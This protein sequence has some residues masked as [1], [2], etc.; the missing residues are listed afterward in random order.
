MN[1]YDEFL[2]SFFNYEIYFLSNSSLQMQTWGRAQGESHFGG[3]L[4]CTF[5]SWATIVEYKSRFKLST[6]QFENIQ[7]LIDMLESF[8]KT[9]DYPTKPSEY[10]ALLNNSEWKEIQHYAGHLY[11]TIGQQI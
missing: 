4:L 3:H 11:R 1:N 10:L 2:K 5:E 9:I 8:Q 7:K 6:F